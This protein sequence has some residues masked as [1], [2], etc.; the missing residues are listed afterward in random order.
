MQ[1][2]LEIYPPNSTGSARSAFYPRMVIWLKLVVSSKIDGD[3]KTFLS[4][5]KVAARISSI[6]AVWRFSE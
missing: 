4:T 3:R 2:F 1:V 5:Q 6:A